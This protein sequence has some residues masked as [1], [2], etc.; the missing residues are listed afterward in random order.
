MTCIKHFFEGLSLRMKILFL[1]AL[2]LLIS[3][4]L[5][6]ME[7]VTGRIW[8]PKV[9][10]EDPYLT[11]QYFDVGQGDAALVV[12][13]E[14]ETLLIDAGPNESER[15]LLAS[16]ANA[17]PGKTLDYAV[18]THS[19]EDHIGGADRILQKYKVCNAILSA[20]DTTTASYRR[21]LDGLA[22]NGTHIIP[23][24]PG[25][26]YPIGGGEITV[27][28]P[29]VHTEGDANDDSVVLRLT[30][31]DCAFLFMGDAE[32]GTEEALLTRF[33]DEA[34]RA[35]VLKM[36]HHGSSTSSTSPFLDAVN[37][38]Y[39]VVSCGENNDYGHPHKEVIDLCRQR[40]IRMLRTDRMGR[41]SVYSDGKTLWV[42]TERGEDTQDK[43][44]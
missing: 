29:L 11:V 39:A 4:S 2:V 3:V 37:P 12:F 18:F 38:A 8:A 10:F 33:D 27:L 42:D 44:K 19:H 14:G 5:G 28:G 23:A 16:M 43:A 41:I 35:D 13:P 40:G 22:E 24:T 36:G 25:T 20:S 31:G 30:Y 15:S 34:L 21:M 1:L 26:S 9:P 6:L 17:M 7:Y 32:R